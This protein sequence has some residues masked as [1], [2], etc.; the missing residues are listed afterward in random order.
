MGALHLQNDIWYAKSF[1]PAWLTNN[2][3]LK[4]FHKH[5]PQTKHPYT[6][7]KFSMR[8]II[9]ILLALLVSLLHSAESF[10]CGLPSLLY[11]KCET[12]AK[13]KGIFLIRLK[14]GDDDQCECCCNAEDTDNS[15]CCNALVELSRSASCLSIPIHTS[16]RKFVHYTMATLG[17][18]SFANP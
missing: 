15:S 13:G 14:S 2:I 9:V 5:K 17:F 7:M 10:Q 8:D 1:E 6:L 16:R 12:R 3:R 18:T 4:K 11:S